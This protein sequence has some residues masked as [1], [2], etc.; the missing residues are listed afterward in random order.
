M[1]IQPQKDN[2]QTLTEDKQ[3]QPTPKPAKIAFQEGLIET[4]NLSEEQ[5]REIHGGQILHG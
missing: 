3:R 1:L 2:S 4:N 5:K